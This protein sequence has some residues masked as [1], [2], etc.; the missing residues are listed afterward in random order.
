MRIENG[1]A[2]RFPLNHHHFKEKKTKTQKSNP[3]A[4]PSRRVNARETC[5]YTFSCAPRI[6]TRTQSKINA[7]TFVTLFGGGR[8]AFGCR[9]TYYNAMYMFKSKYLEIG[10]FCFTKMGC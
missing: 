4:F 1:I 7:E 9:A 2:L 10:N 3:N 5:E 6:Q 8:S